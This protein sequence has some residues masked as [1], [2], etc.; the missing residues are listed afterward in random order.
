MDNS[1]PESPQTSGSAGRPEFTKEQEATILSAACRRVTSAVRRQ[2]AE[3][4]SRLLGDVAETHVYGAFVTLRREGRLRS[5]CGHLGPAVSLCQALDHAA[6][7]AATDDPRFP[8]I[9]RSELN[10]LDVDVWV[11]WGPE[12]VTARG[13]DRIAAV[14]IGKH[15][16]LIER[17]RNRGLLL[18]GVAVEHGFDAKTFLQ[19]VCLKAGLPT[20]AWK[21]DDTNLMIFEGQAIIGRMADA[22][23]PGGEDDARPAAVAGR[24]YPGTPREVQSELDDLFAAVPA[25]PAPQPWPGAMAPHAGWVYSGKL[26]A[27]VFSR[28]AIP[29]CAIVLCPKHRP[30]GA[31]WAVAPHRRWLF[32]GGEL[33]SDPELAARLADGIE[34]LELDAESHREEHAIEV[35]LPLLARLAPQLRVVGITVG[36]SSLP[37]LLRFGVA[38]SVVLRDMPQRPLLL[39]SSDMNHFADLAT[40]Q[41]LDGLA[42]N[43]IATRDP[44]LVYETVRQNRIS[45]CGM[46]PCVVVMEA[47]RWLGSLNRCEPVGRATSA[48]AG[49]PV[50]RVVGYAGLL[51][52]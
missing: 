32:P 11:L 20:D 41:R 14:V 36:D 31:R 35:Q 2:K 30:G 46:A 26:A 48:D 52:G 33:A 8:P 47:L 7:R 22:C 42:L 19:Q 17:G 40:T 50:D 15:G 45:M 24:F 51:L 28:I 49:G 12:P 5:C 27:A 34:G 13:D 44:E 1:S 29:D 4:T 37:E 39:V 23:P 6:D 43:A 38:M 21:R 25:S 10:Q 18:P 3:S 9:A 16:L